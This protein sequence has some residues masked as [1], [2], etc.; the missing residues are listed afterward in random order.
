MGGTNKSLMPLAGQSVLAHCMRAFTASPS[1]AEIV[2][3]MNSDDVEGLLKRW[4]TTPQQL[5]AHC[6]VAGGVE[7]WLS[8]RAGSRATSAH[9]PIVLVHDCA[10]PLIEIDTIEAVAQAVRSHRA[11]LAA[12]PLTD[13]LKQEGPGGKVIATLPREQLWRAQTPQ[14]FDR[15]LLLQAFDHW[16]ATQTDMPTD[17]ATLLEH[18]GHPPILVPAPASN[19]KLT[20]AGDVE[21]AESLLALRR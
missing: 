6:V 1:I 13:T 11:A 20:T 12:E 7:R 2:L 3:V 4:Q 14:G 19:F 8:S 15:T 10:R 18:F 16:Q 9:L 5:G 17:E 21:L